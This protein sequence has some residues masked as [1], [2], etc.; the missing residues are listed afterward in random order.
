MKKRSE[1]NVNLS[2]FLY[3]STA[4]LSAD[5]RVVE[6]GRL[7][8][9]T[10]AANRVLGMTGALMFCSTRFVQ[11]L[12]GPSSV[13]APLADRICADPRHTDLVSLVRRPINARRFKQFGMVYEGQSLFVSRKI[14]KPVAQAQRGS[15]PEIEDL[16]RLM[17]EFSQ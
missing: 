9:Q 11:I 14:A 15:D 17:M 6:F 12:E 8:D 10:V 3:V 4:C 1:L 2:T 5:H 7:V 16:I 13:L